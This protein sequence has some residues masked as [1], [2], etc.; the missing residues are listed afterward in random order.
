MRFVGPVVVLVASFAFRLLTATFPNDHISFLSRARQILH[1][2]LPVRDFIDPG[3]FLA[4]YVSAAVDWLAGHRLIG[5]ALLTAASLASAYALLVVVAR[6]VSGSTLVAVAVTLVAA[7]LLP[8]LMNHHKVLVPAAGLYLAWRYLR[9]GTTGLALGMGAFTGVATLYRHDHGVYL[10]PGLL[11]VLAA[12]HHRDGP[13]VAARRGAA[14][15]AALALVLAPFLLFVARSGGIGSY[16]DVSG[17]YV[18]DSVPLPSALRLL[19]RRPAPGEQWLEWA[20]GV[21]R[22]ALDR[23]R[24]LP[25]PIRAEHA[26]SAIYYLFMGLAIAGAALTVRHGLRARLPDDAVV[27]VCAAVFSVLSA[28][29]FLRGDT[30]N[31]EQL[32]SAAAAPAVIGAWLLGRLMRGRITADDVA[33]MRPLET[34]AP[35]RAA[36]AAGVP[37]AAA[38]VAVVWGLVATAAPLAAAIG[39]SGL[40]TGPAQVAYRASE[41]ARYLL[42]PALEAWA[43]RDTST[44]R[45]VVRYVHDCTRATDRILSTGFSPEYHYFA[46]RAFAGARIFWPGRWFG[47][48]AQ[49]RTIAKLQ[50]ESV[51]IVVVDP[52]HWPV[53]ASHYPELARYLDDRYVVARDIEFPDAVVRVL[54]ERNAAATGT[55][56]ALRLPCFA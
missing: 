55:Y 18:R 21:P 44:S 37:L 5:E 25:G 56:A 31:Y 7:S 22:A 10:V 50:Q 3:F 9:R 40:S 12:C 47:D 38:C 11:V 8:R 2:E 16:V 36:Y 34:T 1:G 49:A 52:V 27:V 24:N 51:P 13:R 42:A 14:F 6:R 26:A 4:L 48:G 32:G 41:K 19:T 17:G 54:V 23:A 20:A 35:T 15:A 30:V 33:Q 53:F 43:P 28:P 46:D 39:D 45:A 29:F